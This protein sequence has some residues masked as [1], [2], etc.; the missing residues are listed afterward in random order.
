MTKRLILFIIVICS[1]V[2]FGILAEDSSASG[3]SVPE[4]QLVY[5]EPHTGRTVFVNQKNAHEFAKIPGPPHIVIGS[6]AK[7]GNTTF[8]LTFEDVTET[9]GDGFDDPTYGA[10][11]R[12]TAAAVATYINTVLNE[13]VSSTIDVDFRDSGSAGNSALA[14]AGTFWQTIPNRYDNGYAFSHITTGIDP[15]GA[16][17]DIFVTVD[18]GYTWNSELD[19]PTGGEMDLFSVLLHE[20]THG[21]GFVG[22]VES[23]GT[24]SLSGGNPGVFT[25]LTDGFTRVTGSVDLWNSS[26]TFV[27]SAADLISD[28]VAFS[29]TNAT[30]ANSGVN[31]KIYAP[32]TWAG[33]SS[34][35]HWDTDTFPNLVMKHSVIYGTQVR[36]YG[37][38]DIAALKDI[39][40]SSAADPSAIPEATLSSS[41][42]GVNEGAGT[43]TITVD[44][45]MAPASSCSVNYAT[46]NGS[47]TAGLDYTSTS[48]TLSFT[49]SQDSKSFTV[50]IL[51]DG[52]VN[53]G[54]ETFTVT[55]SS[56]TDCTI[57]SPS[58]ATV[59]IS[60]NDILGSLST[61]YV[62]FD[63]TGSEQGTQAKP[64]STFDSALKAVAASGTIKVDG[65]ATDKETDWTGAIDTAMIIQASPAGTIRIGVLGAASKASAFAFAQGEDSAGADDAWQELLRSLRSM[66][67][68]GSGGEAQDGTETRA[69]YDESVYE[70]VMP[71]TELD[72]G[73]QAA[74]ADSVLAIRLRNDLDINPESLWAPVPGYTQDEVS[75]E[76]K[77]VHE[78]DMTDVWVLFRPTES[79]YL[80]DLISLVVGAETVDGASAD[81]SPFQFQVGTDTKESAKP[82]WQPQT[83]E[84]DTKATAEVIVTTASQ[85][86]TG[87]TLAE[88]L[89]S[90]IVVG[91]ERVYD[92]P[93]RVWLPIPQGVDA[94]KVRLYYYHANGPEKG[95]YP[96]QNVQGW[97]VPNSYLYLDIDGTTY[98]GFLVNH[99]GIAQLG[100]LKE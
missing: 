72:D 17:P 8:N 91:P 28:D 65:S 80:N 46:S 93:Q 82:L 35:T 66:L 49:S 12:S 39:G 92:T 53:E 21:L 44:L 5:H 79:W 57:G 15:S 32:S 16:N 89:E 41:S 51:D 19:A 69:R 33:G 27:G 58:S 50:P 73:Q 37:A 40:Y 62:D 100:K 54:N 29:G 95:W 90:P 52:I 64:Y 38:I 4:P 78:G 20:I 23:D 1:V 2:S 96:A 14:W 60:D 59:T 74:S 83:D 31:P 6:Q 36:T 71:F 87:Q 56:P 7:A 88:G 84:S 42:Y 63:W 9:T 77:P 11:R 13:T 75:V 67:F 22:L 81:S 47:A 98:L 25:V 30:A 85:T 94:N 45:D 18:F 43:V 3:D 70:R 61:V 68:A 34:M 86:T 10:S 97:L 26:F 99:A 24:S 76:W 48:G 55:I